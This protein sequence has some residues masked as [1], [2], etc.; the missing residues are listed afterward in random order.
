[1]N[2]KGKWYQTF[3]GN[4]SYYKPLKRS[5]GT[6]LLRDDSSNLEVLENHAN[7]QINEPANKS[8]Y[9]LFLVEGCI[10]DIDDH[11][12]VPIIPGYSVITV[13]GKSYFRFSIKKNEFNEL[14]FTWY[15]YG[16]DDSLL[17]EEFSYSIL[18]MFEL[19]SMLRSH[20]I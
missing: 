19:L 5:G 15:D 6:W 13:I 14:F 20:L 10:I 3:C 12:Y 9:Q 17:K 4:Y 1:M 16:E 2:S 7:L 18:Q 8:Y 11:T